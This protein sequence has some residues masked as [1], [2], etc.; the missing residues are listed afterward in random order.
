[1]IY[2]VVSALLYV[3]NNFF[4]KHNLNLQ[5][6]EFSLIAN[7][8]IYTV[9]ISVFLNFVINTG[10][11]ELTLK[12]HLY[13]C[14]AS[15]FGSIGLIF[16]VRGLRQSPLN[17]LGIYNLL[18]ALISLLIVK[19]FISN[20]DA[21]SYLLIVLT[22]SGYLL[23]IHPIKRDT[24]FRLNFNFLMMVFFFTVSTF[25]HWFNLNNIHPFYVCLN[26]EVIVLVTSVFWIKLFNKTKKNSIKS[27]GYQINLALSALIILAALCFGYFG[28]QKVDPLMVNLIYLTIGPI[29]FLVGISFL[30]E[31]YQYQKIIGILIITVC[32]ITLYFIENGIQNK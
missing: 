1:M 15:I 24:F 22:F 6:N 17:Q 23:F 10:I 14:F 29:T 2:S 32:I 4:W 20:Y 5:I 18:G 16:M 19:F 13:A 21:I 31:A 11:S 27:T 26:Q 30:K 7:R 3:V 12:D 8:A 28:L 25:I 9:G